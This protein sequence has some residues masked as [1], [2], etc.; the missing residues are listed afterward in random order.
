MG[1]GIRHPRQWLLLASALVAGC[2]WQ[3]LK[4]DLGALLPT[5]SARAPVEIADHARQPVPE[6]AAKN[7]TSL[8]TPVSPP[9]PVPRVEPASDLWKSLAGAL[10]FEGG[11]RPEVRRELEWYRGQKKFLRET[12]LR[13]SP[14]LH[15]ILAEIRQR[16]LPADLALLPILESG[17][18][19]GVVSPYGAAGLWQFMDGTGSKFGLQRTAWLDERLDVVASTRAALAYL[20]TLRNRFDGDWLL[21]IAAYNAGW[22][23]V[24]RAIARN[25]RAGLPTDLWSLQLGAETHRL[26]A[27][28][29]ALSAIYRDPVRFQLA[30]APLPDREYFDTVVLRKPTDLKRFVALSKIDAKVFQRLNPGLKRWH[31]GPTA[32]QPV[33]VPRADVEAATRIAAR[34]GPS[35]PPTGIVAANEVAPRPA[36]AGGRKVYTAKRGDS[37]WIIARRFDTRVATLEAL[38]GFSRNRPL[39]VGQRIVI[40]NAPSAAPTVATARRYKVRQ[41]DSLWTISRQFK[42]TIRDLLTWNKGV[43]GSSLRPGQ[44]LLVSNPT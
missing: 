43:D 15:F 18:E 27:R 10:E 36:G 23:N 42:V 13:A 2:S 19:P 39:R 31:T 21:A 40:G 24:E 35:L 34:L 3:S 28:L 38:N 33:L 6:P 12:S 25:R 7:P 41:G 29:L 11:A 37:L 26:A 17:Y 14:Y 32:A 16:K 5:Q 44:E 9:S 22:G 8:R 1:G 30:L 4:P 20:D